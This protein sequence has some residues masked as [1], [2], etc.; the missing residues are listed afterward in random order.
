[1][2]ATTGALVV[3]KAVLVA[4]TMP[5]LGRY[6]RAPLLEPILYKTLV[7][8]VFIA[9]LLEALIEFRM[10]GHSLGEFLPHLATIFSWHHFAAIQISIFVL[11][12]IYVTA[13]EL[14]QL[15]GHGELPRIPDTPAL[16]AAAEPAKSAS[17]FI[18]P[19]CGR[20]FGPGVP[21]SHQCCSLPAGRDCAAPRQ[22]SRALL[23]SP[24]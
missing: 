11:L 5:F 15:F 6:D 4:D 16:R 3:G 24:G 1:M 23:R 8:F 21:R 17:S 22:I 13:S 2:L 20:A 10:H 18:G 19:A 9:R 7:Y 14:Y 12:L